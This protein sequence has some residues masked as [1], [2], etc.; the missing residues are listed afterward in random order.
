MVKFRFVVLSSFLLSVALL[1]GCSNT[2]EIELD[3]SN[4]RR[5]ISIQKHLQSLNSQNEQLKKSLTES[6]TANTENGEL[7][8]KSLMKENTPELQQLLKEYKQINQKTQLSLDSI[9]RSIDD[10]TE[11]NAYLLE[12]LDGFSPQDDEQEM[13]LD[14]M[15]TA[16]GAEKKK[17]RYADNVHIGISPQ[18]MLGKANWVDEDND[19]D[20]DFEYSGTTSGAYFTYAGD[21]NLTI[22]VKYMT[23]NGELTPEQDIAGIDHYKVD[24]YLGLVSLGFRINAFETFN[25]MPEFVYG[26]GESNF[27]DCTKSACDS[28]KY[29]KTTTTAVGMELPF[30]HQ[31]SVAFSWGFKLTGYKVTSDGAD[32]VVNSNETSMD[33]KTE[34]TYAGLGLMAGLAW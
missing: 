13:R 30:Y 3:K 26:V 2:R 8:N 9:K 12:M 16:L 1:S 27:A 23:L 28:D 4:L 33:I 22:G 6:S 7:L 5:Q 10:D 18:H 32:R 17:K 11:K 34:T 24:S 21:N 20:V 14:K 31:L 25:I 19:V 29:Y 15:E